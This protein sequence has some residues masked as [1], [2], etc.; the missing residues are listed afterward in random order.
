MRGHELDKR[1][2]VERRVDNSHR[3][4]FNRPG[5]WRPRLVVWPE[6][7]GWS[8]DEFPEDF[9]EIVDDI[10]NE[11]WG[12]IVAGTINGFAAEL[13]Q[14]VTAF[15]RIQP[16]LWQRLTSQ[17]AAPCWRRNDAFRLDAAYVNYCQA[18]GHEDV[19][20]LVAPADV[21]ASVP[22][23][24]DAPVL[25]RTNLLPFGIAI[26]DFGIEEAVME[27]SFGKHEDLFLHTMERVASSFS[28]SMVQADKHFVSHWVVANRSAFGADWREF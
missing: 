9:G 16:T 22:E 13:G 18:F 14:H 20:F 11:E 21:S 1:I 8:K 15:E 19:V 5:D 23:R 7:N 24:I 12:E 28:H 3:L 6:Y 26:L 10:T 27:A 2:C 17:Y 25:D 4:H